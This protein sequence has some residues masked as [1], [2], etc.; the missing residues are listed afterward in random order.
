VLLARQRE[1]VGE[2]LAVEEVADGA[3]DERA[4]QG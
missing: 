4:E 2:L 1:L 3:A